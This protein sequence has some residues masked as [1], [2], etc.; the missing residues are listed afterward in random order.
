M[1]ANRSHALFLIADAP[2]A[3]LLAV[4]DLLALAAQ[5]V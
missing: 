5:N 2:A 3:E 4:V 1:E